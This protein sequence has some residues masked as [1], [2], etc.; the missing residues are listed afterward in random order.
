MQF[1]I[2]LLI[3]LAVGSGAW[4]L[5]QIIRPEWFYKAEEKANINRI[6]PKWYLLGGITGIICIIILWVQ[7]FQ[8]KLTSVWILTA[9]MT[10]GAIKPLGIVF[11]Y[12]KFSGEMAVLVQKMQAS[13]S[14]YWAIVA[15]RGVLSIIL[16]V[17]AMYFMGKFG[18]LQ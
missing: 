15:S 4:T 6:R 14:T 10:F 17:A 16:S 12:D 3:M 8:L 9:I 1:V 11:F 2:T 5:I 7:A 13:K 18:T